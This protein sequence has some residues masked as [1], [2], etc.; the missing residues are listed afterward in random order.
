MNFIWALEIWLCII[1]NCIILK[2]DEVGCAE[3]KTVQVYIHSQ[4]DYAMYIYT[5]QSSVMS[6]EHSAAMLKKC[7]DLKFL[8]EFRIS[9]LF[10]DLIF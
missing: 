5:I 2:Y 7:D 10:D 3:N 8:I 9:N 6:T 4:K 1:E